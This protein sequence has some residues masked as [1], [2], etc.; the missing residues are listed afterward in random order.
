MSPVAQ[1]VKRT[2]SQFRLALRCSEEKM[3]VLIPVIFMAT[4]RFYGSD[5]RTQHISLSRLP[6][7]RNPQP[8]VSNDGIMLGAILIPSSPVTR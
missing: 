1:V 6:S 4:P 7:R 2:M 3:L 5:L 8:S